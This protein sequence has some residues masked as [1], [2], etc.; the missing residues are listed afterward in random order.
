MKASI[1]KE[2]LGVLAVTGVLVVAQWL[3]LGIESALLVVVVAG[4]WG[5]ALFHRQR[6]TA[7]AA[8]EERAEHMLRLERDIDGLIQDCVVFLGD[9]MQ[10]VHRDLDQA[11]QIVGDAVQ[12]LGDSFSGLNAETQGQLELVR[13]MVGDD[14]NPLDADEGETAATVKSIL[15]E[16]SAVLQ[17]LVDMV[18]ET[19]RQSVDTVHRIDDMV[20]QMNKI[21]AL[22]GD[23]KHIADQTNL[24]ALNAAIEAARA[25]E[26]GRGF[27]VVAG[28]VRKLS[29]ES[30]KFNEQIRENV[31]SAMSSITQAR[32]IVG[33]MAAEDRSAALASKGRVDRMLGHLEGLNAETEAKLRQVSTSSEGI[34]TRVGDAV[35]S[36]QFE[37]LVTQLVTHTHER[38][39]HIDAL[40]EQMKTGLERLGAADSS[41]AMAYAR[42][43]SELRNDLAGMMDAIRSQRQKPVF[44]QTM[45]QGDVEL[46]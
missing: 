22:L 32:K 18:V 29:H 24:L 19:A 7:A 16:S 44:Q 40:V 33:D 35:R 10:V 42:L 34:N 9:E 1:P 39:G 20:E 30:N 43:F 25:G 26:A 46:F 28:E 38:V 17:Y 3:W 45:D 36:L 4:V 41:D 23:V 12:T 14:G 13:V 2:Q 11:R 37:D 15:D 6:A 31:N 8:S 21:F 27:A 5:F